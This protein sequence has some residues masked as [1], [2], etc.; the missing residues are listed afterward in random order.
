MQNQRHRPSVKE[1]ALFE[2][3][4]VVVASGIATLVAGGILCWV[5]IRL[6]ATARIARTDPLDSLVTAVP[7]AGAAI[8][9]SLLASGLVLLLS[10]LRWRRVGT[11]PISP[12]PAWYQVLVDRMP[13]DVDKPLLLVE[14]VDGTEWKGFL[15]AV[16]SDPEDTQRDLVLTAP[17]MRRRLSEAK[18]TLRKQEWKSVILPRSEIRSIQ[19]AYEPLIP[20]LQ[21]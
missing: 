11:P 8:A 15:L 21:A 17:L 19:V 14:L 12:M 4:R 16:D 10:W 2:V 1:T 6:Y 7:Y 9:T 13:D 3:A 20:P 18:L 5:W